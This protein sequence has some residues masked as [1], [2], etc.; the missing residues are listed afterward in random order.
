[1]PN[2]IPIEKL[3]E[4]NEYS[5]EIER[6]ISI[7]ADL[8]EIDEIID[9]GARLEV[10][11][12]TP[13]SGDV[14]IDGVLQWFITY[15][16]VDDRSIVITYQRTVQ[17]DEIVT[18]EGARTGME[19]DVDIIPSQVEATQVGDRRVR[20]IFPVKYEVTIYRQDNLSYIVKGAGYKIITKPY[21]VQR[22]VIETERELT[23]SRTETLAE[24]IKSSRDI[25]AMESELIINTV[26]TRRDR[27]IVRGEVITTV[28]Y[29]SDNGEI[30]SRDL[31]NYFEERLEIDGIRDE[32]EAY[33]EGIILQENSIFQG[34]NRVRFNYTVQFNIL[35]ITEEQVELPV[36]IIETDL[37]PRR[38]YILVE[39]SIKEDKTKFLV[40]KETVIPANQSEA[41]KVIRS[42]AQINQVDVDR[43]DD[44]I[45]IDGQGEINH[46]YVSTAPEQPVYAVRDS[47]S[48]SQF[49]DI[50]QLDEDNRVYVEARVDR[51]RATLEDNRTINNSIIIEAKILVTEL[52]RVPVVVDVSDKEEIDSGEVGE[53]NLR[54]V[55]K[56]G[57]SLWLIARKFNTTVEALVALNNISDPSSLQ[58]GQELLIPE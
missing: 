41:S 56:S 4:I 44:G 38:E 37:Y 12:A 49:I 8:P 46:L 53:D 23:I 48:F 30:I 32:M 22:G 28:L 42:S 24:T 18:F 6:T 45:I 36:E 35:V 9:S 27:V 57:D 31:R 33:V 20:L 10:I 1:M 3:V 52:V 40:N 14:K 34:A 13:R 15:R 7:P 55:V 43:L 50:P 25:L 39:R 5:R 16:P 29:I 17:F 11:R 54:Y 26:E 47:F 2:R 58:V 51:I 21:Q 19:V